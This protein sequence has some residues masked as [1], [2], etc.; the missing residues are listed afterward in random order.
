MPVMLQ[1][2]VPICQAFTS[3]LLA[4]STNANAVQV[5]GAGT[6]AKIFPVPN[7]VI[8]AGGT[9]QPAVVLL[10]EGSFRYE[11]DMLYVKATGI[12]YVHG[13]TPTVALALYYVNNTT[14]NS[15]AFK[16]AQTTPGSWT[17]AHT[18]ATPVTLVTAATYGWNMEAKVQGDSQSNTMSGSIT[19][20]IGLANAP[21]AAAAFTNP[22]TLNTANPPLDRGGM[23]S[24][25]AVVFGV[26]VTFGVSDPANVAQMSNFWLEG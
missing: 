6:T 14:F 3:P 10:T 23:G 2:S 9:A 4:V 18:T 12:V 26:G 13:T 8:P 5:S 21:T 17:L 7:S 1:Q 19:Y 22:L 24:E 25:P 16:L 20:T 11:S 15:Q